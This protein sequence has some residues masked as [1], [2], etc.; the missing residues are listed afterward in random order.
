[1]DIPTVQPPKIKTGDTIAVIAPAGPIESRDGLD[2]GILALEG[3]GFHVRF[4]ERIFQSSRYLAGDD[5][6]RAEELM[7]SFEDP[8]I[9]AIIALRGGYGCS[10]LIPLLKEKRLR[11]HPKIFMGFSDLT[12]LHLYFN[13]RF[14]WVTVHGPMAVSPA[15]ADMPSDQTAHL[16]SLW[17]EPEYRPMLN[18]PQL[19]SLNPGVAE[20]VLTGGCL[21]V[22]AASI[23]TPYEI[24]TEGK[25]LFLEDQG[26][27][28]YRIDRM[29]T[30]LFLADKLHSLAGVLLGDFV[31]CKSTQ[32]DYTAMDTLRDIFAS[33]K[34]PVLA[35]FPAGHGVSNWALPLGVTVRMDA[36][37]R[38]IE[39]LEP[40]VR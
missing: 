15:L 13:N 7:R 10:R 4:D 25:I 12:T 2:R 16:L 6:A 1:M 35:N 21:S 20:G 29:I 9:Q 14:G 24:Q 26:E 30:H 36:N 39:F 19:E 8:S 23:G 5:S 22:I 33:L 37:A 11:Y 40:A 32:G 27:P 34:I 17:T 31:D 18:F 3:M 28:P 38:T